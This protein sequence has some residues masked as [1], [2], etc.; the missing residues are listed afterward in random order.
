MAELSSNELASKEPYYNLHGAEPAGLM[1]WWQSL[2]D[3]RGVRARLRR[4]DRPDDAL[5]TDS[6]FQ[7][8]SMMP[9]RW[10]HPSHLYASAL[11]ATALAQVRQHNSSQR[12]AAQLGS[13]DNDRPVMSELRFK[14]LIK[15]RTPEE[16]FRR[17]LRAIRLLNNSVNILSLTEGILHWYE[18]YLQGP[19]R[20]PIK[21]L[22]VKWAQDYYLPRK[23]PTTD[24]AA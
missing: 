21:R 3:N 1:R 14:Q 4:V 11:V 2:D 5:L 16:F 15:S 8:L 9:Q 7:F 22:S 24:T 10:A 12:F 20:D 13:G 23:K 19:D 17:L 6:F 18:E